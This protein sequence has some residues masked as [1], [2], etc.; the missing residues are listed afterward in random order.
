VDSLTQAV[1]GAAVGELVLGKKLGWRGAAWG[2][3][4]GTLPDLD[5]IVLPFL[6]PAAGIRWHR[7]IS[8]SILI[9][10]VA[11]VVLAKPLARRHVEQGVTAREMGWMVFWAW[12]THVLIDCLT[13]YGTQ[14]FEPFS[15]E[16][17]AANLVFIVDPLVTLPLLI[18]LVMALRTDAGQ[19]G[20]RRKLVSLG[21]GVSCLY[22]GFAIVMKFRAEEEISADLKA[23]HPEGVLVAV[24]PTSFNTVLW[25]G[26]IETE[27]G[28]FLRYWSPFDSGEATYEFIQKKRE[29]AREFEGEDALEALKWFS[30]GHWVARMGDDGRMV[31]IDLRFAE[32]R[33]LKSGMLQPIFQWH[34]DR[35]EEGEVRAPMERPTGL[36]YPGAFGLLW[37]RIG[38]ERKNWNALREF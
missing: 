38:G 20:K 30:R 25:R 11:A 3:F 22:L 35:D 17:V 5:V 19:F 27:T 6:D 21:I 16:R 9:M 10:V 33:D 4:F 28:Y 24:A 18:G 34:L 29:L 32:I 31:V 8:H 1:L 36:D 26:L 14:I 2:A 12:S 37:Q 7:G 23:A 15:S 13:T